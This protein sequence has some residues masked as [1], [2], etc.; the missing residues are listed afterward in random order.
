MK[1]SEHEYNNKKSQ[2][3]TSIRNAERYD[4]QASSY[5]S[6]NTRTNSYYPQHQTQQNTINQLNSQISS[7]TNEYNSYTSQIR[8]IDTNIAN[9]ESVLG[10]LND[11]LKD[12]E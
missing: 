10:K 2:A 1:M 6:S 11:Y 7:K 4:S 9:E 3:Q 5:N 8:I 12:F